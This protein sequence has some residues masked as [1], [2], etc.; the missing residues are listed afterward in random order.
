M[1]AER[2]VTATELAQLMGVSVRTIRRMTA[3]GMP[4]ETWGIGH[5]RRYLPSQAIGWASARGTMTPVNPPG[6]RAN[7]DR[8]NQRRE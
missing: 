8:G 4:S 5:V 3:A 7:A 1:T 6:R 2:Y